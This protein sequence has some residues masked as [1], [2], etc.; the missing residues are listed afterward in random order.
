MR[1][2]SEYVPLVG[3]E[4]SPYR[5]VIPFSKLAWFTVSLPFF[6]FAFCV[7]W[8]VL[9]DFEHAT[10]THCQV[11]P[12]DF[13]LRYFSSSFSFN[14]SEDIRVT[15]NFKWKQLFFVLHELRLVKFSWK[16]LQAKHYFF[17]IWR[18]IARDFPH[19]KFDVVH[20]SSGL[21]CISAIYLLPLLFRFTIFYHQFPQL[22]AITSHRGMSGGRPLPLRL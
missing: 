19:M 3:E 13:S 17:V 2:G 1:L 22:S 16:I 5:I 6:G 8:S 14:D 9:Y 18:R 10:S 7:L 15:L 12:S 4:P 11:G 20:I 21:F